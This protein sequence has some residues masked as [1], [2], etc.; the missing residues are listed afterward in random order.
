MDI[1]TNH[2]I[3]VGDG[4]PCSWGWPPLQLRMATIAVGAFTTV[5][6]KERRGGGGGG[7]NRHT[8]DK[9][10]S[11]VREIDGIFVRSAADM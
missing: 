8:C 3:Q 7:L 4:H 11:D 6:S 5:G 2:V 10:M 9:C 1:N